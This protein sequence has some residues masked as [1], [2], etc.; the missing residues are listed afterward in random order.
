MAM[1]EH[2]IQFGHLEDR[3]LRGGIAPRHVRRTLTEL[4]E[5][6]DDALL[7]ERTKGT[8]DAASA[9]HLRL[10]TE[11]DIAQSILAQRELHAPSARFPPAWCL[12]PGPWCC[13]SPSPY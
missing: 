6:Y 13:G 10:G 8:A 12:A 7:D 9:A 5:H 4:R 1:H 3:L 11:N 2:L